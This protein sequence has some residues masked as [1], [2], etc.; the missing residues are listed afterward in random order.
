MANHGNSDRRRVLEEKITSAKAE[1][2]QLHLKPTLDDFQNFW[3]KKLEVS[4]L[5]L[6]QE[7]REVEAEDGQNG[8]DPAAAVA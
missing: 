3:R 4:L 1:L 5:H 2:S 8:A 6:R 7:L